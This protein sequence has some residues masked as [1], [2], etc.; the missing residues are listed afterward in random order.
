MIKDK[1]LYM[2]DD[3]LDRLKAKY[4]SRQQYVVLEQV[5]SGTG[6]YARG[7][8]D[9]VVFHLWPS[10]GCTRSAFEIKVSRGDFIREL[11]NPEKNDWARKHTH[12]F[13]YLAPADVI[14]E[15][16]LPEGDGWMKPHGDGLTIVRHARRRA[17]SG[18]DDITVAAFIRSAANEANKVII[19]ERSRIIHESYEYKLAAAWQQAGE[20]FLTAN[21]QYRPAETSI[22]KVYACLEEIRLGKVDIETR[23]H[24]LAVLHQFQ[25]RILSLFEVF[26]EIAHLGLLDRD[27]LG[28]FIVD[29]YGGL[30]RESLRQL[31]ARVNSQA[32][33]D[34][35]RRQ[36]TLEL[37]RLIHSRSEQR[38]EGN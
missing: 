6:R 32:D 4:S 13:W 26:A 37:L 24:L 15:E 2:A 30:D 3:L 25:A 34:K 18:L 29:S 36:E 35:E 27:K 10:A 28:N 9:A 7:W 11:Q 8:V 12:E 21:G 14:K 1:P 31:S 33:Y 17:T 16:E 38:I 5:A 23:D 19:S 20:K 22:D